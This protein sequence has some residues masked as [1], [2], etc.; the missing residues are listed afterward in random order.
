MGGYPFL[1]LAF[2]MFIIMLYE[3]ISIAR[4]LKQ[5]LLWSIFGFFYL[6]IACSVF[7]VLG[8]EPMRRVFFDLQRTPV[9]LY[10][11]ILMVWIN[12]IS[13]YFFGKFI[14]G[15][16]LAPRISPNKTWAG[17]I[18]GVIGCLLFFFFINYRT[19]FAI[20]GV[21]EK[22]FL[23]ALAAHI[24]IPIVAQL[25]DLFESYLK[26]LAGVKDSGRIIPAHG[27]LLDRMD[28]FILVLLVY[29]IFE[30]I[31]F[32]LNAG[33]LAAQGVSV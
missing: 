28:G 15:P 22:A 5:T 4:K 3:W 2:A 13:S 18:G 14:G 8:L 33:K 27:G 24:I 25:G 10:F 21:T 32:A 1:F 7:F 19:D 29:G 23:I 9:L 11:L 31:N 17:A 30:Y 20:N 6:G 12:D 26:R 16:K